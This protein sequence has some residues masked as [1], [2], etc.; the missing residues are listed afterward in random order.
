MQVANTESFNYA[1]ENG[2]LHGRVDSDIVDG[3]D[4]SYRVEMRDGISS[5]V[6][7]YKQKYEIDDDFSKKR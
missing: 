3:N 1:D 2:D 6:T 5:P 7:E 4:P